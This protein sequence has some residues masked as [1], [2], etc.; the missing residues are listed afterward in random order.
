MKK[1]R[2]IPAPQQDYWVTVDMSKVKVMATD[3][4]SMSDYYHTVMEY[5]GEFY[6]RESKNRLDGYDVL[7]PIEQETAERLASIDN[8][9]EYIDEVSKV[10][11]DITE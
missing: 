4:D 3:E 6:I 11:L 1:F 5:E 9:Q 10:V 8:I 2:V 7:I